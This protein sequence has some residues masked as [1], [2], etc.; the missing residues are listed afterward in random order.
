METLESMNLCALVAA[1]TNCDEVRKTLILTETRRRARR[2]PGRRR[3]V[4]CSFEMHWKGGAKGT[5]EG[6]SANPELGRVLQ[7]LQHESF[8]L[9]LRIKDGRDDAKASFACPL[10]PHLGFIVRSNTF[11]NTVK[12]E[13][14]EA[15]VV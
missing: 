8:R 3:R 10:F 4:N 9:R 1:L 15:M 2:L 12:Q 6:A 14:W 11:L 5:R 13:E 7:L